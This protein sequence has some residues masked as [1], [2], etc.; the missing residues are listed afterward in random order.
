M[1]LLKVTLIG[2][3]I[4]FLLS[5][6]GIR[7]I[8][9]T[10]P[11]ID[12]KWD[13]DDIDK[14]VNSGYE[15]TWTATITNREKTNMDVRVE[16]YSR[17]DPKITTVKDRITLEPGKTISV[18]IGIKVIFDDDSDMTWH[19]AEVYF[20]DTILSYFNIYY[21]EK[22]DWDATFAENGKKELSVTASDDIICKSVKIN[23]SNRQNK[24]ITVLFYRDLYCENSTDAKA[25]SSAF[26]ELAPF[27][28]STS[29]P[30]EIKCISD[31]RKYEQTLKLT[32]KS[33]K[34]GKLPIKMN[35]LFTKELENLDLTIIGATDF[36]YVYPKD[37]E[38]NQHYLK[39]LDYKGVPKWFYRTNDDFHDYTKDD[40]YLFYGNKL[41]II[42]TA[43][44]KKG[45]TIDFISISTG[46]LTR[47]FR[48]DKQIE[49][50]HLYED[51]YLEVDSSIYIDIEKG[52]LIKN[53][54]KNPEAD[55]SY[56]ITNDINDK[57]NER[58]H[59]S[60]IKKLFK[61]KLAWEYKPEG[62]LKIEPYHWAQVMKVNK[63]VFVEV[64]LHQKCEGGSPADLLIR[65]DPKTGKETW[66]K[67]LQYSSFCVDN[68]KLFIVELRSGLLT[69]YDEVSGKLLGAVV[70][71]NTGKAIKA[72]YTSA[73][74]NLV[75]FVEEENWCSDYGQI[76]NTFIVYKIAK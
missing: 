67:D 19:S 51:K 58:L 24:R 59:L 38:D 69:V 14:I 66:R 1:K 54:P 22:G 27:P 9:L 11:K 40:D 74:K 50:I 34:L 20:Q 49:S 43:N 45:C 21:Y 60:S 64:C 53:M 25:R 36:G 56:V 3:L 37:T 13:P 6:P 47:Q 70:H 32:V 46:K 61:D 63:S 42:D 41:I 28:I 39:M 71:K 65:L 68:G 31:N 17:G 62:K 57:Q 72:K 35:R 18:K 4:I 75:W 5:S 23:I 8:E 12:V 26:V 2:L 48:F 52:V 73:V 10:K 30:W 76:R 44:D 16:H 15:E 29:R 55:A 7:S 33:T